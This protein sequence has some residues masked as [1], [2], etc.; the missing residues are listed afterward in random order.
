MLSFAENRK[1]I[2]N[3]FEQAV[4]D[5]STG[6]SAQELQ[7]ALSEKQSAYTEAQPRPLF[8]AECYAFLLDHAQ[9]CIN[10]HTPFSVKF[11]IGVDY[12]YFA[13]SDLFARAI[14]DPQRK[15]VLTEKLPEEYQKMRARFE[16]GTGTVWTDFWHTV[17]NWSYLLEKG[18]PG[19]LAEAKASKARLLTGE[20][21]QK[22]LEFLESVILCYEAILRMLQRMH[23]YSLQFDVP[24]FAAGVQALSARAPQTLYEVMLFSVL[25]LYFE[26]IGPERGR[27]LGPVDRLYQPYFDRDLKNG[28]SREELCEL[29]RYFFLHFTAT[30]RFAEQ[31][32][33]L[34]GGDE[35]GM[36]FETPL[37]GLILDVYDELHI[38]DPKIHIRVCKGTEEKLLQK[39]CDM[40]RRGHSSICLLND[41]AVFRGYE[42]IGIPRSDARDYVPLGCYEPILMG[43]EEAEIG[44]S[45]LNMVKCLEYALFGGRD[46]LTGEQISFPCETDCD[47]FEAF[48]RR[49]TDYMDDYVDFAIRFAEAQSEY[50]TLINPSPIYSSSFAECIEKARDVHEYPLKYNNMSL[51]LFGFATVADSLVAIKKL[52]FDTHELT[53]PQLREILAADWNGHE[54]LRSRILADRDKYG[55][56]RELPDRIMCDMLEHLANRY[57]G[58][59]LPRRGGVLRLGLDSIYKCV[60]YGKKTAATP[61]GRKAGTPV[62]KNLCAS[63]GMD[64]EGITGYLRSVLRINAAD[65]V[66]SAV[67]DFVLHPSAV[68]GERG[69]AAFVS[70]IRVFFDGGG[71]ALQG[72]ILN[73]EALKDAKAHPE[74][75]ATLQVRVCGWNEYFVKLSEIKQ[76]MFIRQCEG[77]S[78]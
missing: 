41:E 12:S 25:Y 63:V 75:Y 64:R 50:A 18:F 17:P 15:A 61:D 55:N 9:L 24:Q 22:Q 62:S 14:F 65:Y 20:H 76:D 13:S 56:G 19:I 32:F 73:A 52:V 48:F 6:L 1:Y 70:L 33:L 21:T 16:C 36:P 31:P 44:V 40:I 26:E 47:S 11:N 60:D 23:T 69:L 3:E 46:V 49:L 10:P 71:F 29:F 54:E 38:Y 28:A 35:N 5:P 78:L 2:E 42:R 77:R 7:A 8:C 72:N 30:K 51:K 4:Y 53:L 66:N 43:K 58:M 57:A 27:S 68:E 39:A 45:W 34:G 37:T 59:P 67:C 74:Q